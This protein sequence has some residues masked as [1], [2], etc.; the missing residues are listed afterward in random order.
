MPTPRGGMVAVAGASLS[1]AGLGLQ[2][3]DLILVMVFRAAGQMP[4]QPS[5]YGLVDGPTPN[6]ADPNLRTAIYWKIATGSETSVAST[7]AQVIA[8]IAFQA[9]TFDPAA[10]V[11]IDSDS[12]TSTS[13]GTTLTFPDITT[14]RDGAALVCWSMHFGGT[15]SNPSGMTSIGTHALQGGGRASYEIIPTAG[16]TGTRTATGIDDIWNAH[17]FSV[18]PPD[19]GIEGSAATQSPAQSSQAGG[20]LKVAGSGASI[21]PAQ[22][23]EASGILRVTGAAATAAPAQTTAASGVAKVA[24]VAATNAPAQVTAAQGALAIV[25]GAAA[26]TAPAQASQAAGVV[27]VAGAAAIEAPAQI[28][29][30]A[31]ALIVRG[32]AATAGPAQASSA[33]GI[34]GDKVSGAA[35]TAAPAQSSEASG[36]VGAKGAAATEAPAQITAA[37]GSIGSGVG[38]AAATIAPAQQSSAAGNVGAMGAAQTEAP[39]QISSAAGSLKAS[40]AATTVA[41]AQQTEAAGIIPAI[42]AI[43]TAAPAQITEG[44]GATATEAGFVIEMRARR[45]LTVDM[46]AQRIALSELKAKVS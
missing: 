34:H 12:H 40:G 33:T 16:A 30:A 23:A 6:N 32:E 28:A 13:S 18:N 10:P 14:E 43:A 20:I 2:A 25:A 26:T 19:A 27:K 9:G 4:T 29:D 22:G 11:A 8:A 36:A 24:G 3:G 5:G 17:S 1:L 44:Q 41:P 45:K 42:G 37:L 21:A 7:S 39:A 46:R 38:G 15:P 35:A 31:G